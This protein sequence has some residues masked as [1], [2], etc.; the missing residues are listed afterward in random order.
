MSGSDLYAIPDTTSADGSFIYAA[1]NSV[2][3]G[4]TSRVGHG[5][6]RVMITLQ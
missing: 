3:N 6:R 4:N 2:V 5:A 1:F